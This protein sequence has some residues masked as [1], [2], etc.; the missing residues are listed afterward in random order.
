MTRDVVENEL[1][2]EDFVADNPH[3]GVKVKKV[4]DATGE[5]LKGAVFTVT[6]TAGEDAEL[7]EPKTWEMTTGE[8][9]I[10][11]EG[12]Y[13]ITEDESEKYFKIGKYEVVET[14]APAGYEKNDDWKVTFEVTSETEDLYVFDFASEQIDNPNFDENQPESDTNPKQIDNP[15]YNPCGDFKQVKMPVTGGEG[16]NYPVIALGVGAA[17]LGLG[18]FMLRRKSQGNRTE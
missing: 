14:T 9:G 2:C 3:A 6:C 17:M 7:E 11:K 18:L 15:D 8:D 1:I 4:D 5:P 16:M 13:T 12:P 10:A